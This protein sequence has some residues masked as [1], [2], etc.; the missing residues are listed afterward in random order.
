MWG[1]IVL[2]VP[3]DWSVVVT[4][5]PI[6]GGIEDKS[7]PPMAQSKRLVIDGYVIMGGIEIKN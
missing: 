3:P 5:M 1:G 7:V 4:G 6:L 2:R